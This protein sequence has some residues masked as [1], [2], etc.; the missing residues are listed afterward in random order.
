MFELAKD[1]DMVIAFD[2]F[3]RFMKISPSAI[4]Q[5]QKLWDT[6]KGKMLLLISGSSIG[7]IKKIFI[8][9]K[10]PLFKRADNIITLRPF[11][12]KQVYEILDNLHIKDFEEKLKLYFLFGARYIITGLLKN[13]MQKT[14]KMRSASLFLGIWRRL[15]QK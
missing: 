4:N 11:R 10:A 14:L 9:E 1:N 15:K 6:N 2:E 5:F 12:F 3:Q 8:E 7:M 13:M